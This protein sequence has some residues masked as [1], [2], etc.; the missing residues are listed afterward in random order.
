M[1][2]IIILIALLFVGLTAA[3]QSPRYEQFK[4]YRNQSDTLQMKQ[5]LDNWG[6]KTPSSTRPGSITA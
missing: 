2:R 6:E 5:M 4:E 3:A 1:K